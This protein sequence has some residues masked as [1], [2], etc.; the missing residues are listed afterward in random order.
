VIPT[1]VEAAIMSGISPNS[2]TNEL[3]GAVPK[4]A[5][6]AKTA[7][8]KS[9]DV[10]G[11]FPDT[12][13]AE[14]EA[15][16]VNPI[17]ATDGPGNPITLAPGEKVPVSSAIT[18]NTIGTGVHDDEELKKADEVA[19]TF[20]VQ[21]IPATGGA[22]NPIKLAAGEPVPA[23][24]TI[25]GNTIQSTVTTDK[26][27]YENSGAFGNAPVLPPAVTPD[28]KHAANGTG[29]LDL[30][31]I[32]HNLIPESS[33]PMGESGAGTFDASPTIQSVGPQATTVF[34]A[35][36][37]PLEKKKK[38]EEDDVPEIVRESQEEAGFAPEA[39]AIPEE[40][41]EK[42]E[43]EKELLAE[44]KK[45]PSIDELKAAAG[46]PAPGIDSRDISPTTVPGSHSQA[47]AQVTGGVTTA[48][49][50]AVSA[51][52]VTEEAKKEEAPA[53]ASSPSAAEAKDAKKKKRLSFFGKLKA[54]F[55]H[56]EKSKN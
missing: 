14:P 55:H 54:K 43:V 23:P 8:A 34:L 1:P 46:E 28:V 41:R 47:A 42:G 50:G 37:V 32:T 16:S 24:E 53:A 17:P 39:S 5:D 49:T 45:V 33:L 29:V 12:P 21:P 56:E 36:Q 13:A 6:L 20:T 30:P 10:P 40:V 51:P 2:T 48:T 35:G 3:A 27:S 15:F 18:S 7:A 19:Q 38:E 9:S 4:E 25:T 52:A 31:P 44:V 26:G 11:A 22:G